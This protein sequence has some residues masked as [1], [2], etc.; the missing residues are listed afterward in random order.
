[1]KKSLLKLSACALLVGFSQA[2]N[3]QQEPVNVNAVTTAVPFLRIAPDARAAGMGDVGIA[4]SADANSAFFNLAKT[5]FAAQRTAFGLT[6][7]PWLRDITKD[8]YLAALSGYHKL[9]DE[10]AISLS[11]RYFNLGQIDFVDFAG[12]PQGSSRPREFA[13]DLGY[14]RKINSKM[15]LGVAMRYINS[16]LANGAIG[17]VNYRPGNTVSV[18]LSYYYDGKNATGQGWAFGAA[19]TN[20]GGKISYTDNANARDYIPANLGLGA[21]YTSVIDEDNKITIA[22]DLNKLLVP[23]P[24]TSTGN[25]SA[26]SLAFVNY[27]NQSVFSSWGKSFTD[28]SFG[29]EMREVQASIGVEYAYDNQF[30]ARAGYNYEDRTKGNRKYFTAGVGVKFSTL[31]LNFSYLVPSGNGI[32]RNPLSNTIRIGLNFH[33]DKK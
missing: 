3:A 27:R 24:P 32:T 4:T 9:D 15:G 23:T 12:N 33:L 20:L 17:G 1:M 28:G 22:L 13:V 6:Y 19:I 21:S 11:A 10:Q 18:D 31:D 30:F 14:S 25:A 8:V 29:N 16:N 7:T 26:D 2:A 5:P